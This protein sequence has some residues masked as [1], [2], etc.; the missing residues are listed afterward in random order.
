[1]GCQLP[2]SQRLLELGA[3]EW[4][5]HDASRRP[6]ANHVDMS[7]LEFVTWQ[8]KTNLNQHHYEYCDSKG[9]SK[10]WFIEIIGIGGSGV[11]SSWSNVAG[12]S[13]SLWQRSL[14]KYVSRQWKTNLNG[15]G[16]TTQ[17]C[18]GWSTIC[19]VECIREKES[20]VDSLWCI[21]GRDWGHQWVTLMKIPSSSSM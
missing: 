20:R 10:I 17:V 5:P 15:S 2:G 18:E 7:L 8:C 21:T 11:I 13:T 1:M 3:P 16:M 12:V 14:V 19:F 9:W 4:F 6:L